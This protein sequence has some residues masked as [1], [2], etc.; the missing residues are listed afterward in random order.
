[1]STPVTYVGNSYSIPAY[2]DTGYAQGTGNLSSYLIALATGS[3]SLSGGSFPL[4]ADVNFG[5]NFGLVALYL[6]SA[7]ANLATAGFLRLANT[8]L[9][10]W[11]NGANGGNDTLGANST[12][13]LVYTG[14]D[15]KTSTAGSG[16]VTTTPDGTKTFRIFVDNNGELTT[17]E[18]T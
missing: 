2:G 15:I 17:L 18:L 3:L 12:D 11:R 14:G 6:K 16:F 9:I 13:Q 1:M 4:T 5:S 8:D 10:E 7:T